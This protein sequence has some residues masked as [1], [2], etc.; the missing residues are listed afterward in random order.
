MWSKSLPL[1]A[2]LSILTALFGARAQA[3]PPARV[4]CEAEENGGRAAA[5]VRVL[6]GDREIASGSCGRELTVPPGRYVLLVRIDGVLGAEPQRFEVEAR[7]GQA[8]RVQ[9]RF[10]TG[11]LL[12]E[13]TR[14]G[15]RSVG[16]VRLLRGGDEIARL[17]AGVVSRV[18]AGRYAIEVESRGST[19]RLDDVRVERGA[20]QAVP[21]MFQGP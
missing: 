21:V 7:P 5:S 3:E 17:S 13:V 9:A 2:A 14:D 8:A 1:L 18:A 6:A 10:E 20:R 12:V 15:R 19:Q 16:L 4:G 11:E